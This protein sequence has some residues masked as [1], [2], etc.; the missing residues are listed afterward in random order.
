MATTRRQSH[1]PFPGVRRYTARGK[2]YL[3]FE[4]PGQPRIALPGPE[5]SEAFLDAYERAAAA[6]AVNPT[7]I[8][9]WPPGSVGA[10]VT[11]YLSSGEFRDLK[12]KTQA[13]RRYMLDAGL[14]GPFG[15]LPA[16][17]ITKRWVK[18]L[19]GTYASATPDKP[20]GR[21]HMWNNLRTAAIVAW[22]FWMTEV[23]EGSLPYNPW[24][25]AKPYK[26]ELSDQ[27]RAWPPEVLTA[28]VREATP[29]FR[30]LIEV[31]LLT[32]QRV[33]DV[34]SYKPSQYD[35]ARRLLT[36]RQGKTGR[37]G[38]LMVEEPLH[39]ALASMRGRHPDR[40]LVS[41]HGKP[42]TPNNAQKHLVRLLRLIGAERYTLHG[43]R[44]TGPTWAVQARHDYPALQAQTGHASL[45]Q[46][47]RYLRGADVAKLAQPVTEHIASAYEVI[48]TAAE[49]E[50]LNQRRRLGGPVG[51]A[52]DPE[53][54]G[55]IGRAVQI[56]Q[57]TPKTAKPRP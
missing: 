24:R 25:L 26:L 9:T 43:L 18:A 45:A 38:A 3:Y 14:R 22:D 44:A 13:L 46:L 36:Y 1:N 12:P 29:E 51:V 49:R 15:K 4:A 57:N 50:G 2:T 52:A 34:C 8:G 27:N 11:T 33:G 31:L 6:A 17:G 28:V 5:G 20:N 56:T 48:R 39:R 53:F 41:P 16:Q 32:S 30:A 37:D 23:A 40:L 35:E 47:R 21:K 54:F 42:W 55:R 19:R 7:P 10:L